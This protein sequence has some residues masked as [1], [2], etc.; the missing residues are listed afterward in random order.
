MNSLPLLTIHTDGA[1]RGNPGS[2]AFAFVIER[3]G[4]DTIEE[5]GCLGELTN[6]QAEYE[7]LVR[8][9]HRALELGPE[10][11][12]TVRSDSE[13]MVKQMI[14]EYRV[15]NADL[16]TLYEDARALAKRFRGRVTFTHVRRELNSRADA[17]CNEAL[18]GKRRPVQAVVPE[19]P[20]SP[21]SA[22]CAEAVQCLREAVLAWAGGG[23]G[24][25]P[26]EIWDRLRQIL[27]GHGIRP[28]EPRTV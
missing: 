3:D 21:K 5:A 22:P 8:A 11:S 15:K 4:A 19:R 20:A 12:V 9:L 18:D 2:A 27:E 6:N 23:D 14:G 13:L 7:A 10:H 28:E 24:P 1:S 25:T 16:L 26:E 17:L